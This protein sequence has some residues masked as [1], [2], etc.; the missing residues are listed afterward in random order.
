[1]NRQSRF[2]LFVATLVCVTA[3][4][5]MYHVSA[6]LPVQKVGTP[7]PLPT[8]TSSIKERSEKDTW[9][10]LDS[11]SGCVSSVFEVFAIIAGGIWTYTLFIRRRQKQPRARIE[12]RITDRPI[13]DG[14][15]LLHVVVTISNM[16]DVLLSLRSTE[17]WIQKMLPL[18]V[19]LQN[20]IERGD[21]PVDK[22][23]TEIQW[24]L[25]E[26]REEKW[27]RGECQVEPGE[28]DESRYDFVVDE[29]IQ[30]IRVYSYFQNV[31]Q[32][33]RKIGWQLAT[34]YD[35]KSFRPE[36]HP[37]SPQVSACPSW[38]EEM[39]LW[40]DEEQAPVR[41]KK[42]KQREERPPLE[43]QRTQEERPPREEKPPAK[44]KPTKV[45]EDQVGGNNT[46]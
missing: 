8:P 31:T 2:L 39:K 10:K 28:S 5:T 19:K 40:P 36:T 21:N 37:A 38:E 23:R 24:H 14:K 22:G 6:Q 27:K 12:H 30:T 34:I 33:K 11:I 18:S 35:L 16:G 32:H 9:D 45:P 42:Q 44:K 29:G 4:V 43:R 7:S 3:L 46:A 20:R 1:M 13:A 17:T 26:V 15:I 41:E 25:L